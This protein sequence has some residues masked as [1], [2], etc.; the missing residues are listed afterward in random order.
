MRGFMGAARPGL[1][2]WK[3][4]FD[5]QLFCQ[6][7][8]RVAPDSVQIVAVRIEGRHRVGP[9]LEGAPDDR[10]VWIFLAQFMHGRLRQ[11]A[12]W[13]NVVRKHFEFYGFHNLNSKL[14]NAR[15]LEAG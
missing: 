8:N 7:I 11:P 14:R 15:V 2:W 1:Y 13:S 3:L 9:Q 6:G 4:D 12:E 5:S 10:D